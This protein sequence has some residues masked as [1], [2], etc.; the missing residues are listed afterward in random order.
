MRAMRH[1]HAGLAAVVL[2]GCGDP[3]ASGKPSATPDIALH[4]ASP[5]DAQDAA[6]DSAAAPLDGP[7][8]RSGL[9]DALVIA[10]IGAW[11]SGVQVLKLWGDH[12]DYEPDYATAYRT[13]DLTADPEEYRYRV[14][15]GRLQLWRQGSREVTEARFALVRDEGDLVYRYQLRLETPVLGQTLFEGE[16]PS[17]YHCVARPGG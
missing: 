10:C 17:S 2:A 12:P 1:L 5:L 6:R 15:G 11:R 4:R 7:P 14:E 3:R 13:D 8:P 9:D 16:M